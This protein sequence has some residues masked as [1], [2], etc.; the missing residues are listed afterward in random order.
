MPL[1]CWWCR[2]F[3]WSASDMA[4]PLPVVECR[5]QAKLDGGV[6][7]TRP[8]GTWRSIDSAVGG[9]VRPLFWD[10]GRP[11]LFHGDDDAEAGRWLV[12]STFRGPDWGRTTCELL[13]P[14]VTFAFVHWRF[15]VIVIA[16]YNSFLYATHWEYDCRDCSSIGDTTG[17]SSDYVDWWWC[18]RTI[19][20]LHS[21]VVTGARNRGGRYH[22]KIS[23]IWREK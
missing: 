1:R 19:V 17:S 14:V 8:S 9:V 21:V 6:D 4:P 11:T 7:G 15:I 12:L 13:P 2:W 22:T 16:F 3:G 18:I 23:T 20:C 10:A 5:V